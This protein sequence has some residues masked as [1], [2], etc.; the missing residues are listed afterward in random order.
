[1]ITQ[2]NA[3]WRFVKL[4][5]LPEKE[6]RVLNLEWLKSVELKLIKYFSESEKN[7]FYKTHPPN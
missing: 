2:Y 5:G 4:G 3:K 1:M 7:Y 6:V